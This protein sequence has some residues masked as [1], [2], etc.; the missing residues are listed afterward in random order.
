MKILIVTPY[1]WPHPGGVESYSLNIAKQLI[2][3]G[4]D[5]V[6]V[7]SNLGGQP[8]RGTVRGMRV[9]R[10]KTFL[11][12]SNTPIFRCLSVTAMPGPRSSEHR[13]I[14]SSPTHH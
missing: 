7:T 11:S 6:I 5:V 9:Y 2:R 1:F 13:A 14:A 8:A 3:G 10:L 4:H 12:A